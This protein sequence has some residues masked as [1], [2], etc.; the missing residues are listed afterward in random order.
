MRKCVN[1]I[2]LFLAYNY[3]IV[4]DGPGITFSDH[5]EL[6]FLPL[7]NMWWLNHI[8]L[9]I[10]FRKNYHTSTFFFL[11]SISKLIDTDIYKI[12]AALLYLA[13]LLRAC[14]IDQDQ[15]DLETEYQYDIFSNN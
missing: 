9:S 15:L 3:Q 8:Q 12:A 2:P 6:R 13:K 10:N 14:L 7:S 11:F 4:V 1:I 5:F